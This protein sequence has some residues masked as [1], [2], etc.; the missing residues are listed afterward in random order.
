MSTIS[1]SDEHLSKLGLEDLRPKSIQKASTRLWDQSAPGDS[2]CGS[3]DGP[4]RESGASVACERQENTA[5]QWPA[6]F[7]ALGDMSIP[8]TYIDILSRFFR[9]NVPMHSP[10]LSLDHVFLQCGFTRAGESPR[11]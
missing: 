6:Q 4:E 2:R 7:L 11:R 1:G 9:L 5:A 10:S 3:S 8:F